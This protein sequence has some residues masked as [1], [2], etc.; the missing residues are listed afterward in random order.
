MIKYLSVDIYICDKNVFPQ[1]EELETIYKNIVNSAFNVQFIIQNDGLN[2]DSK[3]P[4]QPF[5]LLYYTY[6]LIQYSI[7]LFFYFQKFT[8]ESDEGW[9]FKIFINTMEYLQ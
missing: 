5:Y 4:I 9:S 2:H 8:Y 7:R 1:C 6:P 3:N